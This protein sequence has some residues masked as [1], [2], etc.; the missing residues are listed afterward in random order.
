VPRCF[1]NYHCSTGN[2]LRLVYLAPLLSFAAALA[3]IGWLLKGRAYRIALDH[4]NPR[5]LHST[6][7]PRSGGLGLMFGVLAAWPLLP[8]PVL[9]WVGI[10]LLL[11]V[12]FLE[13]VYGVPLPWRLIAQFLAAGGLAAATL[14]NGF[15]LPLVIFA[16]FVTVWMT[17]LYNFMDGSDGLAGG[18]A[19]FGFFFYGFAAWLAGNEAFAV[20]N[21]C[22]AAAAAAFLIFNFHPARVFMGDAGSIPL[23]FL[24]AALGMMGWARGDWPMWFPP[25]VF[26][27]FIVDAS[28]TLLKRL[29]RREKF[30]QAHRGHYYQRLVQI[31]WG[32]RKTAWFEYAL[33]LAAG[34]SALWAMRQESSLQFAL[35][36]CWGIFYMLTMIIFDR[37]WASHQQNAAP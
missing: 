10:G 5:S 7:V 37:H 28:V 15:G 1:S 22:V 16:I 6:P 3:M 21:F 23:G 24:A 9:L 29:A 34:A 20:V 11:M 14:Y 25:L 13:D 30:W 32:H 4:P 8:L 36:V 27:P 18:M 31:G 2:F 35:L 17:N 12:S 26:S 19:L 33:M